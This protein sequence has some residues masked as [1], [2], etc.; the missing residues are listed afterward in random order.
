MEQSNIVQRSEEWE[1]IHSIIRELPIKND[2]GC[3]AMDAPS[4]ATEI[5]NLFLKLLAMQRVRKR[6]FF[7]YVFNDARIYIGF[8]LGAAIATLAMFF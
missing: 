3:D 8:G 2:T 7:D 1:Q 6:S 4:A 5:E